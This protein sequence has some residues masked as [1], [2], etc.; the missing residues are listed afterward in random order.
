MAV[1]YGS[2]RKANIQET[3]NPDPWSITRWHG[4]MCTTF[5]R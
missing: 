2:W 1:M 5:V 4:N 3:F